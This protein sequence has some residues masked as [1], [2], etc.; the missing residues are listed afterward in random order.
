MSGDQPFTFI[1]EREGDS[2]GGVELFT[3]VAQISYEHLW[4]GFGYTTFL[5]FNTDSNNYSPEFTI[6]VEGR[7][8]FGLLDFIL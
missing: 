1:G 4:S 7:Q 5:N 3:G 8:S 6:A 2:Q